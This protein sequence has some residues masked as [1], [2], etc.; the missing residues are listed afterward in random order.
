MYMCVSKTMMM[1]SFINVLGDL[2]F[3]KKQYIL[4]C[5]VVLLLQVLGLQWWS[6]GDLQVEQAFLWNN[7]KNSN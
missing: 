1:I 5:I 6:L 4:V 7:M 3:R 2:V